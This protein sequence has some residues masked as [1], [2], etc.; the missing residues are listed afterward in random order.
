MILNPVPII[1]NSVFHIA[2]KDKTIVVEHSDIRGVEL[3]NRLY[4]DAAD[5]G[6]V[7]Y[8]P[9]TGRTTRWYFQEEKK[10]GNNDLDVTIFAP[11]PETL[12]DYPAN[13][14]WTLHILND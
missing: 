7:L 11:C 4:D 12:R 2:K 14:G 8:N 13:T 10:D 5:A 1:L 6:V 9:V 3:Y